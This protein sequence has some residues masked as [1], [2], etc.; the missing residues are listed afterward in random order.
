[1]GD[2]VDDDHNRNPE[3]FLGRMRQP[4]KAGQWHDAVAD[5]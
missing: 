4:L 5:K 3:S 2:L 1:M